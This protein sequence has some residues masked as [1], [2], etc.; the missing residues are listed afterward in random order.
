MRPRGALLKRLGHEAEA[1][2]ALRR[3]LTRPIN[4]AEREHP[5]RELAEV[6]RSPQAAAG[7]H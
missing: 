5:S 1:A 3:A 4:G 6:A 7:L 2:E